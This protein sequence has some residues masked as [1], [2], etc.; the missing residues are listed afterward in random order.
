MNGL[1][2]TRHKNR[3]LEIVNFLLSKTTIVESDYSIK[4]D[5][6]KLLPSGHELKK[7]IDRVIASRTLMKQR[8]HK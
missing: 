3:H 4:S 1:F 8:L 6:Y 5:L 2:I 7:L